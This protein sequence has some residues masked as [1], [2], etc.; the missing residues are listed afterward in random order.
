MW[1]LLLFIFFSW[2]NIFVIFGS[3]L[4]VCQHCFFFR[5]FRRISFLCLIRACPFHF[6]SVNVNCP[7]DKSISLRT[8]SVY[9]LLVISA[10]SAFKTEE[11]VVSSE[12]WSE[13]PNKLQPVNVKSPADKINSTINFFKI[14]PPFDRIKK[15]Y[16]WKVKL[17]TDGRKTHKT[18]TNRVNFRIKF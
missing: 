8:F 7:A 12:D 4:D 3:N 16:H 9:T 15:L 2:N 10:F 14:L 18:P 6:L 13:P 11:S 1:W 17:Q 5:W